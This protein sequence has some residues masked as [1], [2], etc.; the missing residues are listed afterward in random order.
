MSFDDNYLNE[1]FEEEEE[2]NGIINN[3]LNIPEPPP[4]TP[5]PSQLSTDFI[6]T[7]DY[8]ENQNQNDNFL[9]YQQNINSF[10]KKFTHDLTFYQKAVPLTFMIDY[11]EYSMYET[12][13]KIIVPKDILSKLTEY[14]DLQLPVYVKINDKDNI[15]GIID[16]VDFIDHIYIPTP[17]FYELELKENEDI[18]LSVLKNQPPKA[19]KISLKPL[20]EEFYN[21]DNVKTYLEVWLKKMFI[22]LHMGKIITLPY[23]NNTISLYIDSLE[24]EPVVSIYEIEEVEIDLLPMD[25][26]KKDVEFTEQ[27]T[28]EQ[29]E[30]I[31]SEHEDG[32]QESDVFVSFSGKCNRLGSS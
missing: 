20:N 4:L 9:N 13:Q 29:T 2:D 7:Q 1:S 8:I 5:P 23:R 32:S 16:Y 10:Y 30:N 25:E 28:P 17:L 11:S 18:I 22:T 14:E 12:S 26:Y 31:M 24:P 15:L 3:L 21:L 19:S 6:Q 27:T